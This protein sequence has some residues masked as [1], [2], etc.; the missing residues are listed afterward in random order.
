MTGAYPVKEVPEVF[1]PYWEVKKFEVHD[2]MLAEVLSPYVTN[3]TKAPEHDSW[4]NCRI[5]DRH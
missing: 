5:T 4:N 3:F 1:D 2:G